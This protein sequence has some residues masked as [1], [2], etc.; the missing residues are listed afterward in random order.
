MG[1]P[2]FLVL[3]VAALGAV[4]ALTPTP[5][6]SAEV[7]VDDNENVTVRGQSESLRDVVVALC[8]EA[9]I[10][11]LDFAA[12]DRTVSLR[13]D[14]IPL[15]RFLSRLLREESYMVGL[16]GGDNGIRIAWLRVMGRDS[17]TTLAAGDAPPTSYFGLQTALIEKALSSEDA[18]IRANAL[19]DI[20]NHVR[21]KP[22]AIASFIGRG[23][24]SLLEDLGDQPH[25]IEL[26]RHLQRAT[27]SNPERIQLMSVIQS[28]RSHQERKEEKFK[29]FGGRA[30]RGLALPG[31]DVRAISQSVQQRW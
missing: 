11:L 13:Y 16:K 21:R 28:V 27:D 26:L 3:A 31:Q 20:V 6:D 19:S 8:T 29:P 9:R 7:S 15:D 23:Y 4:C 10:D 14:Q 12:P 25:A 18:D 2:R 24:G 17:R 5:A 1:S 30:L 22:G